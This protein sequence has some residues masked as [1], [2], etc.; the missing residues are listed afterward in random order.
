MRLAAAAALASAA[1][2]QAGAAT[3]TVCSAAP[4]DGFDPTQFTSSTTRDMAGFPIYDQLLSVK[5]GTSELAPGLAQRWEASADGRQ[6]TLHLRRDVA[7]HTTPWFKPTRAMNADDVLFSLQRLIDATRTPKASPWLASAKAGFEAWASNGLGELVTGIEKLDAQ[8]VRIALARPSAPFLALLADDKI[9]TVFSAEYGAALLKNGRVEELNTQPVGTGPWLFKSYQKD[10]VLRL[11]AHPGHWAG[12]PAIDQLVFAMTPDG[13]VRAQRVKAGECLV[14]SYMRAEAIE[15]FK[16]T[17]VRL[18]G[19]PVLITSYIL[20]NTRRRFLSDP[21]FREALWLGIDKKSY[22][23]SVYGGR[24]EVANS[25][26]PS[27]MWGHDASLERAFD[28]ER[29]KALVKASGYDGAPITLSMAVGGSIDG[30]RAGELLQADWARI[31]V[32]LKVEMVEWGELLRRTARG[33]YDLSHLNQGNGADP[34]SMLTPDLSCGAVASGGNRS[35]WCDR[36]LDELLDRARVTADRDERA[37]LYRR[38]QRIVFDA[39]PVIPT[40]YPHYYT[41]VSAKVKG[42]VPGPLSDLDFRGV[43]LD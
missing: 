10:A 26:L 33:D 35:G 29:A 6:I 13:K 27:V 3:L 4:P 1:A 28:P 40:V 39:V 5:R 43:S 15:A 42:F 9:A 36:R 22:V 2:M 19:G 32:K 25:F 30:K 14:G 34:D 20:V 12:K 23:A 16:G 7:F 37:A 41:A 21:R 8:T 11:A 31:G 17:T 18:L 24:A 38:A